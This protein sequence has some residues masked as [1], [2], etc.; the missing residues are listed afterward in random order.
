MGGSFLGPAGIILAINA[1]ITAITLYGDK[2]QEF[3]SINDDLEASLETITEAINDQIKALQKVGLI[4]G[5][6]LERAELAL[7][8]AERRVELI[9]EEIE[10]NRENIKTDI[11]STRGAEGLAQRELNSQLQETNERKQEELDVLS[12]F[13]TATKQEILDLKLKASIIEDINSELV[14]NA[15]QVDNAIAQTGEQIGVNRE[16][17]STYDIIKNSI[18]DLQA[19]QRAGVDLSGLPKD[20]GISGFSP[21]GI[22]AGTLQADLLE[23]RTL[24]DFFLQAGTDAEREAIAQ[25]IGLK[26]EEIDAKKSLLDQDLENN[27]ANLTQIAQVSSQIVKGLF[28][29]NKAAATATAIID[30]YVAFN[31]ALASA[32]PPFN[33]ALAGAVLASGLAQVKRIQQ[34]KIGSSASGGGA[35]GGASAPVSGATS[36]ATTSTFEAARTPSGARSQPNWNVIFDTNF[37][38]KG[39][40]Q[41]VRIGEQDI[42]GNTTTG[43]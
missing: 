32:P 2:I 25:R 13:I 6:E 30:S 43:S 38:A 36:S 23:L 11:V 31:K 18:A 14:T 37:S 40:A 27:K 3:L 41:T 10:K 8:A 5:G 16:L 28:G 29:D 9:N 33:F 15:E 20:D 21:F 35:S 19:Q 22:E 34:T 7:Q 39:M 12:D 1:A 42:I 26:Q 17:A 4:E 24:N